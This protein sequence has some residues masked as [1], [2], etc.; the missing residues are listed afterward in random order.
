MGKSWENDGRCGKTH[1]KQSVLNGKLWN[2][3][4]NGPNEGIFQ[5][6]LKMVA[7]QGSLFAQDHLDSLS[8]RLQEIGQVLLL[9]QPH[10]ARDEKTLCQ[11]HKKNSWL[12]FE[13]G[14]ANNKVHF[15]LGLF[16]K[17]LSNGCQNG[18]ICISIPQHHGA[19]G[20]TSVKWL[21]PS[22][23]ADFIFPNM[24]YNIWLYIHVYIYIYYNIYIYIY[25]RFEHLDTFGVNPSEFSLPISIPEVQ[26]CGSSFG[27]PCAANGLK[28]RRPIFLPKE[29]KSR[30]FL[31]TS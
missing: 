19:W 29:N 28:A 9:L 17:A 31:Q 7:S 4:L 5:P 26:R 1:Y 30:N 22:P 11:G 2:I 14:K 13:S 16:Q 10:M 25:P 20:A 6:C 27:R 18:R 12:V 8:A 23:L 3:T 24:G 15:Y 21:W